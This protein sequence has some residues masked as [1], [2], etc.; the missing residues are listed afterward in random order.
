VLCLERSRSVLQHSSCLT[1]DALHYVS[2]LVSAGPESLIYKFR[3]ILAR[4]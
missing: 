1:S 4:S 3:Y 2:N